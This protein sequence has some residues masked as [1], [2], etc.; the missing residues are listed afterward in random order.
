MLS[1]TIHF[2]DK[3]YKISIIIPV[4]NTAFYL[5]TCL[6]SLITQTLEEIEIICVNDGSTDNSA[7]ILEEYARL[8]SRITVINQENNG[9]SS[10]RNKGID[11]A[12]GEY[13]GFLDS[14]DWASPDMFEKLY[15][16]AQKYDSQISM[17]SIAMFNEK[18]GETTRNDAY[19]SLDLFG[20][21]FKNRSFHPNETFDFIFRICVTPWN[22]I[23][24]RDFLL[25]NK[26][27]FV[28]N[29]NFEDNVFFLDAYTSA[30]KISLIDEPLVT[31]RQ[32][33]Q[34]SYSYAV[35]KHD[36]KRLDFFKIFE[37]EKEILKKKN[38]YKHLKKYFLWNK[39]DVLVYWYNKLENEGVK[40]EY[41]KKLQKA[42]PQMCFLKVQKF[43][44]NKCQIN[45]LNNLL[46]NNK[47]VFWGASLYLEEFL[48]KNKVQ[49]DNILGIIDKSTQK[50]G[51]VLSGY[52]I[53]PPSAIE[54]LRPDCIVPA[55]PNLYKFENTL[56]RELTKSD[57]RVKVAKILDCSVLSR[58]RG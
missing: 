14:D 58:L 3:S 23:Y 18:T 34:T 10:A 42:F 47:I 45:K 39:A 6:K 41:R 46:K 51:T 2:M 38:L 40:K 57:K 32:N 22:K 5:E 37:L 53:I 15:K 31:Y 29:L 21:D 13:I 16:N 44:N 30:T 43:F 28:E 7:E 27:K 48:T 8:D 9:Q 26:L 35:K 17:C 54:E 20:E 25:Q 12:K 19:M 52:K 55:V 11:A 49:N 36:K 33:S 4:Y 24:K 50:Q 1:D 56:T